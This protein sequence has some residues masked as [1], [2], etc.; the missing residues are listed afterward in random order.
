MPFFVTAMLTCGTA[1][2]AEVIHFVNNGEF[3]WEPDRLTLTDFIPGNDFDPTIS[4][5]ENGPFTPSSIDYLRLSPVSSSDVTEGSLGAGPGSTIRVTAPVFNGDQIDSSLE[6]FVE[7]TTD[8]FSLS[9]GA[10]PN[11]G[12]EMTLGVSVELA[13][14]THYGWV[15]FVW[16]EQANDFFSIYQ[17]V[18]WAYESEPGV[19]ITAAVPAPASAVILGLFGTVGLRRRR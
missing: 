3:E 18:E 7:L 1:A 4:A 15:H 17:P 5:S 13:G 16:T 8:T 9:G 11:F 14:E 6:F 10:V 12:S 2:S 19:P